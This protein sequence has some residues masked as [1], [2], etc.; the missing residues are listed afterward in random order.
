MRRVKVNNIVDSVARFVG[1]FI[2]NADAKKSDILLVSSGGLGDTILF[3]VIIG[4]FKALLKPGEQIHLIVRKGSDGASFLFPEDVKVSVINYRKF[5]KN[6]LYRFR[7]SLMI[8]KKNYRIAISTDHLRLP[9]IDDALIM[10]AQADEAFAL[11][12]RTWPKHDAALANNRK[13]Y[14]KWIKP[15][16][17]MAHRFIRW[18][19]LI[20]GILNKTVP[21]PVIAFDG[22]IIRASQNAAGKPKSGPYIII[23]P[24]ST[25]KERQPPP[26]IFTKIIAERPAGYRVVITAAPG[27]FDKNPEYQC[28][29]EFEGVEV[30]L[31]P[32]VDKMALLKA[33]QLVVSIDTSIMHLAVGLGV[34]TLCLASVAHVVDSIPYD[35]RISPDNV[36]F[37][38]HD[39]ECR[40]CLGNCIYPYENDRYPCVS[41]L[42]SKEIADSINKLL[43]SN[44]D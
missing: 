24:F 20:C 16:D 26:E 8:R 33:A 5:I 6:Y 23:H 29:T 15:S 38:V 44:V 14:T 12:P 37:I 25:D 41:R 36:S 2:N 40:G 28:L 11:E 7:K 4:Q 9:T 10:A 21:L 17:G 34:K 13:H 42:D 22:R 18:H 19:E 35:P 1:N 43:I 32:L 3:A 30:N 39:M 27:D 31:Q